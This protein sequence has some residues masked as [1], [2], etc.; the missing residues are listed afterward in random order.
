MTKIG[1]RIDEFRAQRKWTVYRLAELSGISKSA[2]HKWL[3]T[4]TI[5]SIPAL[6]QICKAFEISLA[7]FFAEGNMV[8]LTPEKKALCDDYDFLTPDERA[9]VKAIIKS[10]R[11]KK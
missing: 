2:I 1:S 3:D 4:D 10:Y 8:E 11:N 7:T 9:A 6:E 5:P